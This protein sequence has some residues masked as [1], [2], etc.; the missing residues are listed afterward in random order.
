MIVV[1][2]DHQDRVLAGREILQADAAGAAAEH[3]DQAAIQQ[4]VVV[5]DT[6]LVGLA[7]P[8]AA[9]L[10][11]GDGDPYPDGVG[12]N[13]GSGGRTENPHSNHGHRGLAG[14]SEGSGGEYEQ[15]RNGQNRCKTD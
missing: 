9:Q 10:P 2:R 8:G 12:M 1:R 14:M 6:G 15:Q 4:D 5:P 7:R 3:V 13:H 11:V